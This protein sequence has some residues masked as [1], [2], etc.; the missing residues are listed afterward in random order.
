[1]ISQKSK[2]QHG[3]SKIVICENTMI[4]ASLSPPPS[5]IVYIDSD[6]YLFIY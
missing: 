5:M 6:I 1:M 3:K 4:L 2:I